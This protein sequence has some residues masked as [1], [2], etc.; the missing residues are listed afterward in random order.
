LSRDGKWLISGAGRTVRI[1]DWRERRVAWGVSLP[2]GV[3]SFD[4]ERTLLVGVGKVGP[5]GSLE[6]RAGGTGTPTATTIA[7]GQILLFDIIDGK[8]ARVLKNVEQPVR[9]LVL[10]KAKKELFALLDGGTV[11]RLDWKT[12]EIKQRIA[13]ADAHRKASKEDLKVWQSVE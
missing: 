11:C 2:D 1:W 7:A 9:R 13:L 8:A 5:G 3:L 6:G 4:G 12:G 10:A